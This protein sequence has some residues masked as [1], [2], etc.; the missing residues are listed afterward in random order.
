MINLNVCLHAHKRIIR[1]NQHT[2][3]CLL[4][5]KCQSL[6]SNISNMWTKCHIHQ[7]LHLN[8]R[9]SCESSTHAKWFL[10]DANAE[11]LVWHIGQKGRVTGVLS[12]NINTELTDNYRDESIS[13][14]GVNTLLSIQND[15]IVREFNCVILMLVLKVT[16]QWVRREFHIIANVIEL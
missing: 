13:D 2:V 7:T 8:I 10:F 16:I 15:S 12:C 11:R 4:S 1:A 14:R 6:F 9:S 3:F 5:A